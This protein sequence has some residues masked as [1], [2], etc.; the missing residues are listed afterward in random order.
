MW[1]I[2]LRARCIPYVTVHACSAHASDD[3]HKLF[4]ALY[5]PWYRALQLCMRKS[6]HNIKQWVY[7]SRDLRVLTFIFIFGVFGTLSVDT[8]ACLSY[9]PKVTFLGHF[10]DNDLSAVRYIFAQPYFFFSIRVTL[11]SLMSFRYT[12]KR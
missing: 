12:G 5:I 2:F 3:S 8:S 10:V 1:Q 4:H 9:A 7:F 11:D 6:S